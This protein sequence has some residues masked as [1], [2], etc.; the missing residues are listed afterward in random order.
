M[1][2]KLKMSDKFFGG[3][4]FYENS[5]ITGALLIT[6]LIL[7]LIPAIFD[8]S[9]LF[10][11]N[12][13][14][15]LE[16]N[17]WWR[18]VTGLLVTTNPDVLCLLVYLLYIGRAYEAINGRLACVNLL[19]VAVLVSCGIASGLCF[20][21]Y[22]DSYYIPQYALGL[23]TAFGTASIVVNKGKWCA[24][25]FSKLTVY[26]NTG[27]YVALLIALLN[28]V[29]LES[30][31]FTVGGILSGLLIAKKVP[32]F[33]VCCKHPRKELNHVADV[34]TNLMETTAEHTFQ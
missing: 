28:R 15:M 20:W 24:Q 27:A 12:P 17:Q 9:S 22:Y 13:S 10:L 29:A 16:Q 21:S 2:L 7:G 3:S 33:Y 1:V 19:L 4:F 30:V 18:L 34:G 23:G 5:V 26:N 31:L 6:V 8:V 14:L 25:V 32:P 11:L